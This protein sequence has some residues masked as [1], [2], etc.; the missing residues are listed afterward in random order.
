MTPIVLLYGA[1]GVGKSSL[2]D[3]GLV[4]R[5]EAGGNAV[6]YCRRDQQKGLAGS[7]RLALQRGGEQT[8]LV[9]GWRA[10]EARLGKPLVIFLDQVEEVFTRPNPTQ[11]RELDEFVAVL[12]TALGNRDV[13]PRGKLVLGF[14]KEWLAELDRRLAEAKLPRTPVFL[15]QLD[16]R[17]IIEAI[18]G[19]ARPGRLQRHYRLIVEDGLPEIIADNLLA[20]AGS[21]LAPT[22][23]VLLTKMWERARQAN[24]DQPRF[25]RAL[26]ESLKADGYLLEDVLGEGLQAIGHW[27][28]EV[29]SSGLA[30]DVLAFH[31]TDLGTA[32]QRTRAELD[33]RYA[34]R[35]D[36]LRG[37][38]DQCKDHYLLIEAEPQAGSP[39]GSTR[40]AH[41]LLAPL[42]QQRFRLSV[43]PGE[44]A[45]RVLENRAPEWRDGK[46]GPVLDG[47]DLAT[48]EEGAKGM[49]V[50]TA[51]ETR[52]VET[53]RRA[54]EQRTVEELRR[55][56]QLNE[57]EE[58]QRQAEADK[59]RETEQRL[60]EQEESNKRLRKRAVALL[61]S[62]AVTVGVAGLATQQWREAGKERDEASKQRDE[63]S[64][65]TKIAKEETGSRESSN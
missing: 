13:R 65:E 31:T 1:S 50:W 59:Q 47:T 9:E 54:E 51:D 33:G 63:A 48:V 10:D 43:A 26:Y 39:T 61:A 46:T 2:L 42:V 17:G 60:K 16:R 12:A 57:A 15:K 30:L 8:T 24:A 35:P 64:K 37:L 19:P 32:G 29:E 18:R 34:H 49:R 44:R 23:Q 52:L 41:D 21:A 55:T 28:P 5:L 25:D 45:R 27:N 53:S 62:L 6:R 38:V 4:P 36:V 20:D 14:R 56:R 3:A 7:L 11:P 40:L 22:L 58:R